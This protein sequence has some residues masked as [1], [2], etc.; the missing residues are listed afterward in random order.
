MMNEESITNLLRRVLSQKSCKISFN[1]YG[2][3]KII[4]VD[5]DC[6]CNELLQSIE[7]FDSIYPYLKNF[8]ECNSSELFTNIF[9]M[10]KDDPS[11]LQLALKLREYGI[12][13]DFESPIKWLEK[14]FVGLEDSPMYEWAL[15]NGM[16]VETWMLTVAS[17]SL[18]LNCVQHMHSILKKNNVNFEDFDF[19][20]ALENG[21]DDVLLFLKAVGVVPDIKKIMRGY[22]VHDDPDIYSLATAC[23][24]WSDDDL[25]ECFFLACAYD[26]ENIGQRMFEQHYTLLSSE[27]DRLAGIY[28]SPLTDWLREYSKCIQLSECLEISVLEKSSTAD[29]PVMLSVDNAI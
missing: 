15:K 26:R 11:I 10:A 7:L 9:H 12:K 2:H 1:E 21:R 6:F 14:E 5:Q 4:L 18:S 29:N 23:Y 24:E 20:Y 8:I 13:L 17:G 28:S 25:T 27:V 16:H 19:R 22:F 3:I